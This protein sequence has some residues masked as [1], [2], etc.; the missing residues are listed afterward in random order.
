R[1]VLDGV[2]KHCASIG[3]AEHPT[4]IADRDLIERH[5]ER[6]IVKRE[7]L[8]IHLILASNASTPTEELGI[9]HPASRQLPPVTITLAWIAPSL[10]AVKGIVHAPSAKPELKP[11]SRDALLTAIVKA[12]G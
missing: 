5:V 12:R 3:E 4:A 9:N 10:A 6:V 2:R 8:E 7:A 11:E 1:L